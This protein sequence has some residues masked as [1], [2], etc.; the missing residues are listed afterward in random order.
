VSNSKD[1]IP[2]WRLGTV[3]QGESWQFASVGYYSDEDYNVKIIFVVVVVV[4]K[5]FLCFDI[6]YY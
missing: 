2:I 4:M 3:D 6:D 5:Y 1:S